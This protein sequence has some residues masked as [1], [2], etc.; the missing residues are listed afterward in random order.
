[1]LTERLGRIVKVVYYDH[2]ILLNCVSLEDAEPAKRQCVGYL[3]YEDEEEMKLVFDLPLNS[4]SGMRVM[5][6]RKPDIIS[7]EIISDEGKTLRGKQS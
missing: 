5:V 7:V 1:M 6:L 4:S 2:T 3:L